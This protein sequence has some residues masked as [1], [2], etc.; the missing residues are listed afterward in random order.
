M[1]IKEVAKITPPPKQ[2][3]TEV[4]V[5]FHIL[6]SSGLKYLPIFMGKNPNISPPM[7]RSA[8]VIIFT[9][10]TS[11]FVSNGDEIQNDIK[12]QQ[13]LESISQCNVVFRSL[14]SET[15]IIITYLYVSTTV[16]TYEGRRDQGGA[17]LP[18]PVY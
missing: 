10:V 15:K 4:K 12:D 16:C 11:M 2:S 8:M 17:P 1:W 3:K 5:R 18:P 7:P 14:K 6:S 13:S 9:V